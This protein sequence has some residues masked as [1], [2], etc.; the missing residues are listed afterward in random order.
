MKGVSAAGECRPKSRS[1]GRARLVAGLTLCAA[2]LGAASL[3]GC[4]P[5]LGPAADLS[6]PSHYASAQS[7]AAPAADWPSED[8][9][10]GYG[11]AQLDALEARALQGAPNLRT[12]Q[13]RVRS[14]EALAEQSRAALLPQLSGEASIQ[15]SK[16]SVN[17][18][19]PPQFQQYLPA[20]YHTQTRIAA[21][22]DWQLDFFG[23]NRAALAAATS[24]AQAA[25]ADLAAARLELTAGVASAYANLVRLYVDRDEAADALRVRRQTLELVG[26]RLRNGL[27]TRG[28]FSQQQETIPVAQGDIDTFDR[29]IVLARHQIAALLGDGPDAGLEIQRPAD[30]RLRAY[31]LP[32]NLSVDLIGRRPDIAAARLRATAASSQVKAAKADF[33]PNIDLQGVYGVQSLGIDTLTRY[34]S[35]IGAIGPAIR[36][37]I[38]SEGRLQGA[39]RG[40]RAEYDAAVGSYDQALTNALRDV[41]DAIASARILQVQIA[42]AQASQR[43]A[44]DA[45][46][47]A[48]LRYQGALS[49]YLT[50]LTAE[51]G[52]LA[53]RRNVADLKAQALSLDVDL[54][55]ALGGGYTDPTR[56]AANDPGSSH[57][58]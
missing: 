18:G 9:W 44:E 15:T 4:A 16:L 30:L 32:P 46:H 50:V 21:D 6:R 25:Q 33:Y 31:G 5:D 2:V 19:Y 1:A 45:F 35:V 55:R 54:I 27:E 40:A 28:E 29:Q 43:S 7:L 36:L 37:P 47:I 42:D 53:A 58:R 17:E 51:N 41:A 39:Y 8:W 26:Q 13:A 23:R 49:P 24:Q 14:A 52:V 56:V 48:T 34:G 20:G 3:C 57:A 11:D 10:T 12:A 38:F 22:L